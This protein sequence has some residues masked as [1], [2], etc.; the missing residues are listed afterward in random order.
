MTDSYGT[1]HRVTRVGIK[2]QENIP[3]KGRVLVDKET[4]ATKVA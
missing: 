1:G 2:A 4:R 3:G